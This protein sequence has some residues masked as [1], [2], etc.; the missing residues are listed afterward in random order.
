MPH[1]V[2]PQI[3]L[4]VISNA[5]LLKGKVSSFLDTGS[6]VHEGDKVTNDTI[7]ILMR[8]SITLSYEL[9]CLFNLLLDTIKVNKKKMKENLYDAKDY[10]ASEN[11]MFKLGKFIGRQK[12]HDLIHSIIE[13]SVKESVSVIDN[14]HKSKLITKHL[15]IDKINYYMDPK[16]YM[17][18]SEEISNNASEL[19]LKHSKLIKKRL[20]KSDLNV[21]T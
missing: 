13:K 16:N 21:R 19:G 2:N 5:T 12:S 14:L 7:D 11:L 20:L 18:Q 10:I 17:G 9:F 6:P 3:V 8:E 1:K 4:K 15:T